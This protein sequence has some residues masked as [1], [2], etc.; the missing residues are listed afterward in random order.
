MISSLGLPER[1]RKER[2]KEF[3]CFFWRGVE[4]GATYFSMRSSVTPGTNLALFCIQNL[5]DKKYK[6]WIKLLQVVK[7]MGSS[8]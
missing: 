5:K 2:N 1:E 3:W 8:D 6:G 4:W 7:Q